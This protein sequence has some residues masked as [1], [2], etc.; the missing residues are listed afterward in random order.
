MSSHSSLEQGIDQSGSR[1]APIGGQELV[2]FGLRSRCALD[3]QRELEGDLL[4]GPHPVHDRHR[5]SHGLEVQVVH[6]VD[7]LVQPAVQRVA[8]HMGLV[9]GQ[10]PL[11]ESLMDGQPLVRHLAQGEEAIVH[12]FPDPSPAVVEKGHVVRR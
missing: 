7:E 9:G 3:V 2:V 5:G 1:I 4:V 11:L 6:R 10:G 8:I 12:Q